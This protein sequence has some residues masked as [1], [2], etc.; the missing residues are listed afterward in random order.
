MSFYSFRGGTCPERA[1]KGPW[2][3]PREEGPPARPTPQKH[4]TPFHAKP[5]TPLPQAASEDTSK[6]SLPL[7]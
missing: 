7:P 1:D 4:W 6:F 2:Q 3:W 5:C